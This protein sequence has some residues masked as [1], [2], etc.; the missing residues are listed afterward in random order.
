MNLPMFL[1]AVIGYI[2]ARWDG[3]IAGL[4]I[5][6]VLNKFL[7]QSVIRT[8]F[9]TSWADG[10]NQFLESTFAVMG[11]ACKA[12]GR[13]TGD[14]IRVAERLFD[15]FHLNTEERNRAIKAFN[16]GKS[17]DFDLDAEVAAFTRS[18]H[19]QRVLHRIFLQIQISAVTADGKLHAEE[20]RLLVRI[21]RGLGLSSAEIHQLEVM[22]RG[23]GTANNHRWTD[24]HNEPENLA[25]AY[26][27][28]GV[29]PNSSNAEIKRAYRRLVSQNHPDKLAAR[30]LPESMRELADQKT[31]EITSAYKYI[32][33]SRAATDTFH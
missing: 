8:F 30:G 16:R 33:D 1:G 2:V 24:R 4:I 19:G 29:S 21:A 22:L 12:D 6:Y 20:H 23:G 28:L 13:I 14:E 11:A 32:N 3:L 15:Q 7:Y 17:T 18:T 9:K 31:R 10:K 25:K 27:V 5:G 26:A